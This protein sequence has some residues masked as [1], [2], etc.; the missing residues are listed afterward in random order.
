LSGRGRVD[1]LH[2]DLL[3]VPRAGSVNRDAIPTRPTLLRGVAALAARRIPATVDRVVANP[4]D[5]SLAT[6]VALHTGLSLALTSRR[7]P[8]E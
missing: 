2:R 6:A 1:D 8:N 5:A 7:T 4:V 3:A